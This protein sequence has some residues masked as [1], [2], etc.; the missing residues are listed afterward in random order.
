MVPAYG[1]S[2]PNYGLKEAAANEYINTETRRAYK[3]GLHAAEENR[4]QDEFYERAQEKYLEE[5]KREAQRK[6]SVIDRLSRDKAAPP[7]VLRYPY[8]DKRSRDYSSS[9]ISGS[10]LSG[11]GGV[12]GD[13][14]VSFHSAMR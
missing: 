10:S 1:A 8:V 14:R 6:Q 11:Y 2:S 4:K 5:L 9:I 3:R 12:Y 13:R 7:S